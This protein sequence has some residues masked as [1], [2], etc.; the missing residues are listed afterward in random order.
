MPTGALKHFEESVQLPPGGN[1]LAVNK[2]IKYI[3]Q[4]IFFFTVEHIQPS[5]HW[6]SEV[7]AKTVRIIILSK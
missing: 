2:Y 1:P 6:D 3:R 5:V 4:I 7:E